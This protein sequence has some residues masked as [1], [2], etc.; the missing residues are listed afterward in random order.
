MSPPIPTE[1]IDLFVGA[2][3]ITL[4][5]AWFVV[6][7]TKAIVQPAVSH[8]SYRRLLQT[9][10]RLADVSPAARI[11]LT[12]GGFTFDPR[13]PDRPSRP[14]VVLV[15]NE[16]DLRRDQPAG[17]ARVRGDPRRPRVRIRLQSLRPAAGES[18]G[19]VPR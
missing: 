5:V 18:D 2:G 19:R 15:E 3:G 17:Q 16:P 6:Q 11:E 1:L 12:S 10:E 14:P 7:L 9:I 8:F 4:G 13:P